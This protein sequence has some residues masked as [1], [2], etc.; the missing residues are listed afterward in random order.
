M[1]GIIGCYISVVFLAAGVCTDACLAYMRLCD[2]LDLLVASAH[3]VVTPEQVRAAVDAF[4]RACLKAGWQ[5]FMHPKFHWTI[6]LH[7]ELRNFGMLLTCWVH[8][9]KHRMVKRYTNAMRNTLTYESSILAEVTCQHFYNLGLKMTFD[10]TIGLEAPL[11]RCKASMLNSLSE[12]LHISA[13]SIGATS[14][15]ARVS[16][17]EVVRVGDVV[18]FRD[19]RHMSIGKIKVFVMVDDVPIAVVAWWKFHS[20][21][22]QQGTVE[23]E[24]SDELLRFRPCQDICAACTYRLKPDGFAQVLVSCMYRENVC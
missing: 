21:N 3:G 24:C 20:K 23:V 7:I 16:K 18:V 12:A 8:E 15:T 22:M 4:L 6:H 5:Q 2:V 17:F 11:T 10:L 1:Y 13:D 9:R 19:A 14:K